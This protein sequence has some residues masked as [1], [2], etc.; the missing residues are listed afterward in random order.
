[1]N[2]E[3]QQPEAGINCKG[4]AMTLPVWRFQLIMLWRAGITREPA[5]QGRDA[6]CSVRS[7]VQQLRLHLVQ[8]RGSQQKQSDT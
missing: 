2:L 8:L 7:F 3:H 1:M 4:C 5:K 6:K